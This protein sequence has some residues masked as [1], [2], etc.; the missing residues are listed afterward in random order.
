MKHIFSRA[1]LA[2]SGAI[3]IGIGGAV[4]FDPM[5]FAVSN[6]I[7][8]ENNPSL[9]SEVRAPGGLLLIS[10]AII[11]MGAIRQQIMRIALALAALIYGTYG[12]S[13]LIS[14]MFDGLP[15]TTLTQA[16][17]LELALGAISLATLFYLHRNPL[18]VGQR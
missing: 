6:G 10:G 2:V 9:M 14:M 13:R 8:L 15:S 17:F 1:I 16:A 3:L 7:V 18:K 11:L 5:S 12:L 4:L